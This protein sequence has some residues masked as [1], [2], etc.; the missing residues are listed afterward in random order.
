MANICDN[1]IKVKFP[2]DTLIAV[3]EIIIEEIKEKC[4]YDYFDCGDIDLLDDD[5]SVEINFGSRW[6]SRLQ[7]LQEISNKYKVDII[8]V[9]WEFSNDYADSY[10][11]TPLEK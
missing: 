10:N 8:G 11:I 7:E 9:S 6:S 2:E 5:S 1:V 3:K 4:Y